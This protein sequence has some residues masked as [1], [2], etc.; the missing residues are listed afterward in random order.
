M[1]RQPRHGFVATDGEIVHTEHETSVIQTPGDTRDPGPVPQYRK[2]L[3]AVILE[4]G[5]RQACHDP[6]ALVPL[7]TEQSRV[8]YLLYIQLIIV[9]LVCPC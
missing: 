6:F 8:E 5:A 3:I 1:R 4:P 9:F 2:I 7:H